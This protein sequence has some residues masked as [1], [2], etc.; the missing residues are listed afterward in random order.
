MALLELCPLDLVV[1]TADVANVNVVLHPGLVLMSGDLE[2]AGGGLEAPFLVDQAG[3]LRHLEA[4]H[5]VCSA[6]I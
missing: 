2:G 4:K 6:Q 5:A 3:D 1:E